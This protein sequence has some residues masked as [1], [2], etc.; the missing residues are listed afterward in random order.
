MKKGIIIAG[1]S[2]GSG[3]TTVS[4]GLMQ[5]FKNRGLMVQPFKTGPDYI[6]P[7]FHRKVLGTSSYNLPLWMVPDETIQYLFNKRNV[8]A[9]ITVVEGVMGY[10]DGHGVD[11]F[12]GSTAYLADLLELPVLLV[13]NAS[14]MA[15]SAA[16]IV[17]GF[18]AFKTPTRIKGVILNQVNSEHHYGMLKNAIENHT[19]I[20]CYGYLPKH[21]DVVIESRH[22]GLLQAD[23]ILDLSV[24][25]DLIAE[26]LEKTVDLDAIYSDFEYVEKVYDTPESVASLLD[27]IQKTLTLRGSLTLGVAKDQ[28]FSFYYDENMETL[29]E[30]GVKIEYFSPMQDPYLPERVDALYFGGGYPEVFAAQLSANRTFREQLFLK[31]EAGMPCYAE[32]G[33]LMY[34][35]DLIED[36][37]GWP[38]EMVGF[39]DINTLMTKKLQRFGHIHAKLSLDDREHFGS[40]Y[41]ISYRAHEFHKSVLVEHQ[42]T[43]KIIEA[44]KRSKSWA[45]GYFREH[46]LATY[47]HNHFYSNLEFL[48]FLIDLWTVNKM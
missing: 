1:A 47:A 3:K 25:V 14:S 23:E 12:E 30:L 33:G 44:S 21:N 6:D 31:L 36:L 19:G 39:F 46:T 13:F 24:K 11:S 32:C 22:L 10:Y 26:Q 38:F 4:I 20:K 7:M 28:A 16:A 40:S 27:E 48:A 29:E 5:A 18:A 15:L 35:T 42:P 9:D 43:T 17:K 45:C 41:D 2:S 34:L 37:D 8:N